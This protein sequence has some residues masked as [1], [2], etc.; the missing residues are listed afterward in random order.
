MPQRDVEGRAVRGPQPEGVELLA[1]REVTDDV[2]EAERLRSGG[3]GE[4]EQVGGREPVSRGPEQ[5]LDEVRL[6]PLLE[7][8]EARARPD[9]GAE[10]YADAEREVSRSGN[11]PLPSAAL[12][13]GQCATSE[14]WWASRRSSA[15]VGC[16]LWA[17]TLRPLSSPWFS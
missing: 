3:G 7:E 16:T 11:S 12:L 6:Q 17:S 9:V 15:S 13:V 5:L 14:S 2:V 4:V 1:E 8:R 10:R